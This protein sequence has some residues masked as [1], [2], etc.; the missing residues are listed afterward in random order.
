MFL[1]DFIGVLLV[2]ERATGA[3]PGDLGA[4]EVDP[5]AIRAEP[6]AMLLIEPDR[7]LSGAPGALAFGEF[8]AEKVKD[9]RREG[10]V[11][12]AAGFVGQSVKASGEEG[13]DPG[14]DGLVM[15]AEVA[16]N[17]GH[18]PASIRETNHLKAVAGAGRKSGATGA[19]TEVVALLISQCD[20][21][22]PPDHTKL[23]EV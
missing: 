6:N 7:K 11:L 16:G 10:G 4:S 8:S 14:A 18:T 17:L 22:H 19:L 15:L 3:L 21:I 2:F 13:F 20:T 23:Y 9:R 12:A 5:Q 1:G